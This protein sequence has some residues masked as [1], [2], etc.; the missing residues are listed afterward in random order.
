MPP[1]QNPVAGP[2]QMRVLA[3]IWASGATTVQVVHDALNR[4]P[5]AP[6]LAYTTILTVMRNLA[7]R[8]L[9]TQ[10]RGPAGTHGAHVF[11]PVLNR[12]QYRASVARWLVDEQ[13]SGDAAAAILAIEAL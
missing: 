10:A 5:H 6:Q 12:K 4:Q 3:L 2:L 1:N 13:F 9:L 7:R 8:K 11:A